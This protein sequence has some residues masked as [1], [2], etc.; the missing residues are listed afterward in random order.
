MNDIVV[1]AK[2]LLSQPA[3]HKLL[4]IDIDIHHADGTEDAFIYNPSVITLSFHLAEAAFFPGT[5]HNII[6]TPRPPNCSAIRV[7]LRRGIDDKTYSHIFSEIVDI[8][9]SYHSPDVIIFQSGC[10]GIC[11]D[12]RGGFNLTGKAYTAC[13]KHLLSFGVPILVLGGGGYN[14]TNAARVWTDMLELC[15]KYVGDDPETTLNPVPFSNR[16]IPF[17]DS[18]FELYRPSFSRSI[19]PTSM[20]NENN[21]EYL[22]ETVNTIREELKGEH[23]SL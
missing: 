8:V 1:A 12:P 9:A 18:F 21:E 7:P 2:F 22:R 14:S 17:S 15:V 11:S 5:G 16:D 6:P 4:Y 19:K 10:D 20:R 3:I 23:Y 13:M